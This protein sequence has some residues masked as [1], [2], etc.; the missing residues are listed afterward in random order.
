MLYGL[1]SIVHGSS[2]HRISP[3]AS[4]FDLEGVG[5]IDLALDKYSRKK[6]HAAITDNQL[7]SNEALQQTPEHNVRRM[8][9]SSSQSSVNSTTMPDLEA[10]VGSYGAMLHS[11]AKRNKPLDLA[12]IETEGYDPG[13]EVEAGDG[14]VVGNEDDDR[15][16]LN[17]AL[18]LNYEVS[19]G[20]IAFL[21]SLH[22]YTLPCDKHMR[23]HSTHV[24]VCV[25]H[26]VRMY[27]ATLW[28]QFPW[29]NVDCLAL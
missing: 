9:S 6:T 15:Y 3:P 18:S 2:G 13:N 25:E 23:M 24:Y 10:T 27:T 28:G 16:D 11:Y 20:K 8:N 29:V 4:E 26:A 7:I 12:A 19:Y 5:I 14:Y 21:S 17:L 22:M 1:F